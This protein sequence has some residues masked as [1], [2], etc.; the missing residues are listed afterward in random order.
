LDNKE[1]ALILTMKLIS[2]SDNVILIKF[3][4]ASSFLTEYNSRGIQLVL[5]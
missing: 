2:N 3:I 5:N 4:I 1:L